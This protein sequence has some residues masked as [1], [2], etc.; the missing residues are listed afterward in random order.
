MPGSV[1]SYDTQ[2]GN[3]V[4]LFYNAPGTHTG[5]RQPKNLVYYYSQKISERLRANMSVT[6]SST[7]IPTVKQTNFN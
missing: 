5:C 2:P 6:F 4:G 1:A 3:E 7:P